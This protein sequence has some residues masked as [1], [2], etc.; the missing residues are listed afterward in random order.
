MTGEEDVWEVDTAILTPQ[1][2]AI[3][4]REYKA[5]SDAFKEQ[6]VAFHKVLEDMGKTGTDANFET[7]QYWFSVGW[8]ARGKAESG[9]ERNLGECL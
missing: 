5:R 7:A 9:D 8:E 4:E 3:Y 6:R 1:H 2:K